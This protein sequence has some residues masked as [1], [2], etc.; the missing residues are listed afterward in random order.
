V[1]DEVQKIAKERARNLSLDTNITEL[2]LD[3]LERWRFLRHWKNASAGGFPRMCLKSLETCRDVVD[4][5]RPISARRQI[6]RS[7]ARPRH[8]SRVLPLR[9]VSRVRGAEAEPENAEADGLGNPYFNVHEGVTNDRTRIGGRELNSNFSNYNYVGMS[10]DPKITAAA[11]EAI[12][13]F[14]TSVSASRLVSGEKAIHRQL[15]RA[16]ADLVG[17]EDS[18]V[19]V[20]GHSTNET[21]IGHLFG[22]GRPDPARRPGAQQHYPRVHLV[23][24]AAAR[25]RS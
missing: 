6:A 25:L 2:G 23:G 13:R 3:S 20:G 1:L 14:G 10:G 17:A 12:D 21:T 7:R 22:P 18:I 11:K 24:S 15:E 16:I 8:S 19:Y 4:A 5:S 9:P